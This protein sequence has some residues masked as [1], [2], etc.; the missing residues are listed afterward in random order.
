MA[1]LLETL[2]LYRQK[3]AEKQ[4]LQEESSS[5]ILMDALGVTPEQ[6][7]ENRQYWG[8][9][10]GM[11]W[12]RL[13]VEVCSKHCAN[14]KPAIRIGNDEPCDLVVGQYAIDTKYRI[15]SG[16]SGTHKKLKQYAQDL[17]AQGFKPVLLILREDNL[18]GAVTSCE[19]GGWQILT[20]KRSFEFVKQQS[21]F[22]LEEYLCGSKM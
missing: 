21:G 9:E 3:F 13:V 2:Q 6:K 1:T 7:L 5:D 16:D 15:G 19:Q 14:F 12:Q 18:P 22:D 11:C 17:K 10:L 4:H 8:R 20:G